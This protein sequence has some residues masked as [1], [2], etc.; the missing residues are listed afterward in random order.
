M[1][2]ANPQPDAVPGEV[3]VHVFG[4][5]DVG[6][7]REHNEDAFVVADLTRGQRDAAAGG[8]HARRRRPQ[9][10]LFM[11]ADGM[12]GAAAGEIASAMAVDVVLGE[13]RATWLTARRAP[14][15]KRSSRA[16]KRRRRRRTQQIHSYAVEHPEYPRHGH[17]GDDRRRCSATRCT[18][19]RSATAA[20]TSC[21]TAWREQITKDQSLMQKLIEAGELT[22]EEA[23]QSERRNIILQALGPEPHDQDRS[24]ASSRCAAATRSCCAATGCRGQVTKDEIA[25]VVTEEPDLDRRVQAADRSRERRTAGRT[26]S[27]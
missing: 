23:E 9:G 6:R 19:R 2:S 11:V 26:T 24:H 3:I 25:R 20:R 27:R 8:A 1:T 10:S 22:E 18:S 21:A 5:T 4:R 7:T 14:T 13:L 16:I 15:R 12:G 17:D